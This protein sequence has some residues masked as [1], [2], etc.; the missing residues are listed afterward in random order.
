M[1]SPEFHSDETVFIRTP[2]IYIKS[3]PFEGILTNKRILLIDASGNQVQKEI[4]LS[5]VRE[6]DT[7]ENAIRDQTLTISIISKTGEMRKMILTFP[8]QTGGNRTRERDEWAKNLRD[9]TG[10]KF[11]HVVRQGTSFPQ[12]VPEQKKRTRIGV[13]S[14]PPPKQQRIPVM[15]DT[16][17]GRTAEITGGTDRSGQTSA[18][19]GSGTTVFGTYCSRCGNRVAEGS[20]FCNRCGAPIVMPEQGTSP[21]GPSQPQSYAPDNRLP[22]GEY[23]AA[24]DT[25]PAGPRP[26]PAQDLTGGEPEASPIQISSD[27]VREQLEREIGTGPKA[28]PQ[29]RVSREAGTPDG[30]SRA[31]AG[32]K[33]SDSPA[34]DRKNGGE[35]RRFL[36][37][38][39]SPKARTMDVKEPQVS[40]PSASPSPKKPGRSQN[41]KPG[42]RTILAATGITVVLGIIILCVFV[43][44]PMLHMSGQTSPG[45][46]TTNSLP[47][48]PSVKATGTQPSPQ[49][50][51]ALVIVTET[52][53]AEIPGEGVQVHISYIGG[54][55]GTYGMPGSFVPVQN[56]GDRVFPVVNATGIVVASIAK[57][58][59]STKHDLLVEIYNDGKLL[60]RG[61]TS[62]ANGQVDL[63]VDT[64]TGVAKTPATS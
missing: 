28:V 41:W 42:K 57:Q 26:E 1:G 25:E 45:E 24:N 29:I 20:A 38:I 54:F 18:A 40:S 3:F 64:L 9:H 2:S 21:S 51:G 52:P 27:P 33:K 63:S 13:V 61:S 43:V 12:G 4:H 53:P 11:G 10:T 60:T 58:D 5:T 35:K 8:Q 15:H 56:S 44:L 34:K 7:G 22:R 36:P 48:T 6:I 19:G 49:A 17:Q 37:R 55:K 50:T 14:S 30:S 62:S 32:Q 23:T 31:A 16:P 46:N 39:F 47:A 59:A